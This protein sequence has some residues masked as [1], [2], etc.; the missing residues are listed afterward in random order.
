MEHTYTQPKAQGLYDPQNEHE[1]CGIGLIVDM[2]GR[3]SHDIVQGALEIC[4]NLDHRGGCGCDPITGDGAGIF[5]Q[6]PHNFFKAVCKEE[7]GFDVPEDGDYG[8]GFVFLSQDQEERTNEENIIGEIIAEEGFELLGWRDV[9]VKSEILGKA[10]KACEPV[11]RQFFIARGDVCERG[12]AFERKLYLIRRTATHRIRYSGQDEESLFY[13]SSLSSRTMTYKGMLT[14][15]QLGD[16]F[17]DLAHEAMDS[18]LALTHSRFSTNTFPSWPRAQPFRYLCHNGEINTVRGNENWLHA[19][20]MQLASE[21]F[22]D[23]LQKLLPIIREDGSDSQKFDNCLEFLVLSGRS[24]A[25]AMMMMIPEPWERHKSMPQFKRDFYEFHA[26]MMEPWDGPAS[27]AMSDGVQV[28]ATLD[29]NGLRPSRYYVTADDR[30]ILASEV[31]VLEGIEPKNVVKKGRLEPGR[32]FLIDM[33][34]GRIVDDAELKE[35]IAAENPYGEWLKDNLVPAD[36]LPAPEADQ[37]P[38][39]NFE[40]LETRQKAF[41]YTFE[42]M[43]FIV[44]PSAQTGK[45]PLGSMGNDA[46]LAVLSDQPQLMYNYFKQLFAQVTNP[47]IDPIREELVTASVT[48]IGSEGDLTRPGPES[49]RMIKFETPLLSDAELAQLRYINKDG[50]KATKLPI[51]FEAEVGGMATGHN[52]VPEPS[53]SGKGLEGAL[54]K[55][56]ENADAAI[57]DGVN[58]L[59]LSDRKVGPNKAPI[60][61]LLAVAGLHH[62]LVR[63]G[64]R[65]RVSIVLE[66]GEPREVQHF[67]LLLGYGAN[68]I[69]PY[70]ALETVRHLVDRG[71]L[72]VD[73]DKACANF[74]KANLGGVIKTM[75]KMGIS[76]VASYRGAQ[77]FEAI[78]LNQAVIDKYFTKTASRVEGIGLGTIAKE[79]ESRHQKAFA[80]RDDERDAALDTGG[81]YQWRANGERHLFN[82]VTIHKLQMATRFGD[83]AVFKEYS[84]AI[85]DQSKEMFTLRGLMDFKIDESKSIPIEEVEPIEEIMKRFKTGAMSYGSISKEAHEAIAIAMNRI[86]GKSNTGEGGE[87]IDRFTPDENGDSR[88]SA[89]KQVASGRFGV[90]SYY[91]VNSDEIQIKIVQGAK[92]GEGGELPGHKV[93]PQI[94]KTRGTTPGVGLISPPP[95]H[96][97]YSIEDLAEL[98]HDLKNSN[99]NARVNVKLVSEVGVGTIAAGVAKAKADVILVSGYDGGT[100]ASPRSSIQHAGAPWELGLA[101]TNQTLLLNDLRS[102][103][104]VETDGQ[105]KTGRDVAIACLLG[106]EEFGFATTALVTL[107][108]L[109]MRVCHKNTCPVGVATQNPELRKKFNGDAESV[110]NFMKYIATEVREYMA[111]LGYRSINE[112]VGQVQNLE[113]RKAVDHWKAKGLDYSKILYKPEVGPEVGTF[114]QMKQDHLLDKCLDM[115]EILEQAQPAVKDGKAVEINLPIIN[116]DRVVGTITG[117]EISRNHG[118]DGLPEDTVQINLTGSAG[119]SLGA[120][121]P[122]GMTFTVTG[123]TNDYLG[124]GLSGGKI[125][126]RP[127]EDSPFVAHENIITGNVCFYG[128]TKGEA[129]IAGM[130]G[131]RFCVRNSGVEA[132]I[133]GVGDHALEY[134]TGGMVINLGTTGRNLGAGM[135]GG[136]AYVFDEAG[137]FVQH[138][139][140][141]DMVNV[142]QLIECGDDEINLVKAKIEKH[143]ELTGSKRGQAILADWPAIAGKFLKIM[144]QDYERVLQAQARAEERGLKGDDA[145]LAAFEENVKAG[146]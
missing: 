130:A 7:A 65:T 57:R 94:A 78:G 139:L 134:M 126:V 79:T 102:R 123:D 85:N 64:T 24:L 103:V 83:Y 104:V 63:Q 117:A 71:D 53:I 86:G 70:L 141:P 19:R 89:I 124:K 41:G 75:S 125:V 91:L 37:T 42:D 127:S 82:P 50:F 51:T 27:M 55:L 116:T 101:E 97:I 1:N 23:D 66:S 61:A 14:T 4:V 119:Q 54:E 22:G 80:P 38:A 33:E 74:L 46:P 107:G 34:E 92:P 111:K 29:R 90:T 93:L 131:E 96:D 100:G 132:V 144:P 135:S 105:L 128:A 56:F 30:V 10:S 69:N 133:E 52:S 6:L 58:I 44:G 72:D 25:H 98:I 60:P 137:D 129:Y 140:N 35:Q 17:P 9:P 15:E 39:D 77:I 73:P 20:Q 16:Y 68:A 26:C 12:L 18:A 8:V 32:M 45:Q 2:K 84:D 5:I 109:M 95:H 81:I 40:T 122:Q 136:V 48:F 36:T 142:Y 49:C 28:G 121:C 108:C 120:F 110:V 87:D 11:M 47:P 146:H 3:K 145:I 115:R 88:R 21:V 114:C 99:V 67:A 143:V 31:G 62:H 106:A 13:I 43:R 113:M 118:P 76:T 112:M 59:I 138:S